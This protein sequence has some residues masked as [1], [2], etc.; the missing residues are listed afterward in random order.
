MGANSRKPISIAVCGLGKIAFDQ[1]FP[2]IKAS[3]DFQLA[4]TISQSKAVRGVPSFGTLQEL[5][6]SEIE[7][8]AVALC[9]P[10]HPRHQIAIRVIEAGYDLLLEKPPCATVQE[11]EGLFD[12]AQKAGIT[13]FAS[14]HSKFAP[15]VNKAREWIDVNGCDYFQVVWSENALKWHPAQQ[16]VS[17]SGGFG[18]FDPGINALSILNTIFD[19]DFDFEKIS[20]YRPS[21]WAT[22]I[23]ASFRMTAAT[24][25]VGKV[26][27][28]WLASD[29]DVWEIQFFSRSNKMVLSQGG[30]KMF[31]NNAPINPQLPQTSEYTA[32][33]NHFSKLVRNRES[34]FDISPLRFV[35]QLYQGAQWQEVEVF[36]IA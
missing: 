29:T 36:S 24:G 34:D 22:P 7:V 6:E 27:F 4:A 28:D 23:A 1:H 19:V 3:N 15:M 11:S 26:N 31:V 25:L 14:W 2:S 33:Y 9:M 30:H 16:W 18:V 13:I 5:S 12:A 32:L 35:E 10:P 20:F 17:K 21:N 8:D